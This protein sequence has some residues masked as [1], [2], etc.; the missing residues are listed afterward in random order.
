[1]AEGDLQRPIRC[2]E[3]RQ[4]DIHHD[5]VDQ[6]PDPPRV[7]GRR[8][9]PTKFPE[10]TLLPLGHAEWVNIRRD[11]KILGRPSYPS[12]SAGCSSSSSIYRS[13]RK[14][15]RTSSEK[16]CG[17]SQAAKCPPLSSSL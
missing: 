7:R 9:D 2:S 17:C 8:R 4:P 10:C 1:M 6:M 15:A 12:Y 13:D 5:D 11:I 16:S 14:A 3:L